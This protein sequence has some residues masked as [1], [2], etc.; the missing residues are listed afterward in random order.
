MEVKRRFTPARHYD[1]RGYIKVTAPIG[2]PYAY[3]QCNLMLEH[4]LVMEKHIGR[5]LLPHEI[6]HH[7]NGKKDDNRI[8]NLCLV[9][10]DLEHSRL[11]HPLKYVKCKCGCG[12]DIETRETTPVKFI[13]KFIRGHNTRNAHYHPIKKKL[14]SRQLWYVFK[15]TIEDFGYL[16]LGRQEFKQITMDVL[17]KYKVPIRHGHAP[18]KLINNATLLSERFQI[19]S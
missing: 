10:S 13:R 3:K 16:V 15:D 1:G 14:I 5:Y 19:S 17:L 4:R 12:E 11:H 18:D 6:V 2:H 8:E 9:Q 7:I